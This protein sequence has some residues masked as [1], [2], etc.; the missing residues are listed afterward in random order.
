M[1]KVYPVNLL[2]EGK[3]C[4]VIGGG[5][6]AER[7]VRSLLEAGAR[8]RV[9]APGV[10][11]RIAAWAEERRVEWRR[12][13][14]TEQDLS[15]AFL[16]IA[17]TDDREV[18]A[19][20]AAWAEPAGKLINAVDQPDECNFIVPATVRR[21]PVLLT[22]STGGDSPALAKRLRE[23]LERHIGPE[24][25]ELAEMLGRLR[26]EVTSAIRTQRERAEAWERVLDSEALEL[27]RQGKREE[28]E[29]LVRRV[30]LGKGG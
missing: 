18:N 4:V 30:A 11:P 6:V 10:T 21:G 16:V 17:A 7:K 13:E 9:V 25:G 12:A 3:P 14:A 29:A 28:A 22:V 23:D 27:L 15:D 5:P 24:Y 26:E 20:V 1:R 19:R 2:L 8:V